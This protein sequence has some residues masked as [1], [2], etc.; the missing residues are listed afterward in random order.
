MSTTSSRIS[1]I[2]VN[3]TNKV[4]QAHAREPFWSTRVVDILYVSHVQVGAVWL[5]S[6]KLFQLTVW[7]ELFGPFVW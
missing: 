6:T 7:F 5:P 1:V 4:I 2:P 3:G